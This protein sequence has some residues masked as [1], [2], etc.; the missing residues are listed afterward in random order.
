MM[1]RY[2]DQMKAQITSTIWRTESNNNNENYT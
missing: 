1:A 2:W